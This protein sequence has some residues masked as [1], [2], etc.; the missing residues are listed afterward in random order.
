VTDRTVGLVAGFVAGMDAALV[1]GLV[2]LAGGCGDDDTGLPEGDVPAGVVE[3]IG[4]ST[5]CESL[6]HEADNTRGR[7]DRESAAAIA[8]SVVDATTDRLTEL[9]CEP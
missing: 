4:R 5:D 9:G 1:V 6:R 3:E 8:R 7:N 2:A